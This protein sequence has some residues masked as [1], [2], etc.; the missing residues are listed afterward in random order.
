MTI[1]RAG[2]AFVMMTLVGTANGN[3]QIVESSPHQLGNTSRLRIAPPTGQGP[4]QNVIDLLNL[5][6]ADAIV[7]SDVLPY[8]L[9]DSGRSVYRERHTVA[10]DN[11]SRLLPSPLTYPAFRNTRSRN[12]LRR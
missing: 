12:F 7:P 11:L 5:R 1:L 4:V 3:A 10:S 8:L 9:G 2:L 6:R